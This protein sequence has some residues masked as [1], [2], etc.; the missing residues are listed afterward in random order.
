MASNDAELMAMAAAIQGELSTLNTNIRNLT[1]YGKRSRK[2]IRWLTISI[3]FDLVLSFGLIVTGYQA[4]VTQRDLCHASQRSW[5][6]RSEV[7]TILTKPVT[8]SPEVE[9]LFPADQTET[10]RLQIAQGNR[11]RDTQRAQLTAANGPRPNC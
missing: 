3:V 8:L 6:A 11:T 4:H 5:D 1:A 7:T 10:L 2:F 9:R